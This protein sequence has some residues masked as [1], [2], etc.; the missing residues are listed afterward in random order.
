MRII[1][2][3]TIEKHF[4]TNEQRMTAATIRSHKELLKL[5]GSY[6]N[7]VKNQLDLEK[8]NADK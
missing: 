8:L 4:R 2:G 1:N 3:L 7:L 6:F 5:G